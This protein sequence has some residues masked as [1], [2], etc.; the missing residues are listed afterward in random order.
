M[1]Q[2]TNII[3]VCFLLMKTVVRKNDYV[4]FRK[5]RR[6]LFCTHK[7]RDKIKLDKLLK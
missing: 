3:Q 1:T 7:R 4:L 2:Q 5:K 6:G